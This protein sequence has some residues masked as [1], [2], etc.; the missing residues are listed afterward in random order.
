ML[1]KFHNNT[2]FYN[3]QIQT[4]EAQYES[5]IAKLENSHV[6][7]LNEEKSKNVEEC[8]QLAIR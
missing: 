8:R 5:K 1:I 7:E 4:S 2:L 3:K 6:V